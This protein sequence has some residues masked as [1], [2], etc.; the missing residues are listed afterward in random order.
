MSAS[1]SVITVMPRSADKEKYG[2]TLCVCGKEADTSIPVTVS[3]VKDGNV[4]RY[5]AVCRKCLAEISKK[6]D[7]RWSR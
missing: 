3:D 1:N 5:K 7:L 4:T 6:E 2:P